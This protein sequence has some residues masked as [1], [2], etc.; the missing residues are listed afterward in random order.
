MGWICVL[1]ETGLVVVGTGVFLFMCAGG[2]RV[3]ERAKRF[4]DGLKG[5]TGFFS[6]QT[7]FGKT[8]C[9]KLKVEVLTSDKRFYGLS[10]PVSTDVLD[11]V[12]IPYAS[13]RLEF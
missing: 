8:N 1:S 12:V 4:E 3:G 9:K 7:R 10:I 5:F 13:T 6:Q 2:W 11:F